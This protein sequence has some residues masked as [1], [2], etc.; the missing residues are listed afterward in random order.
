MSAKPIKPDRF[1]IGE[2][3]QYRNHVMGYDIR[4]LTVVDITDT[5]ITCAKFFDPRDTF[6]F[7]TDGVATNSRN[8]SIA[9]LP[10]IGIRATKG[11]K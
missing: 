2:R 3:V 1:T 6:T 11:R 8:L 9:H 5:L 4:V 7:T 10:A